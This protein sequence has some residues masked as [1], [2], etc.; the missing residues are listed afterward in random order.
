MRNVL[1]FIK[2]KFISK[3]GVSEKIE[4]HLPQY[5]SALQHLF[6]SNLFNFIQ[7][8]FSA[9]SIYKRGQRLCILYAR[10]QRRDNKGIT[11]IS[12][13]ELVVRALQNAKVF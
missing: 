6:N 9:I 11:I 3:N 12:E 5:P 7:K 1:L 2:F 8:I 10:L 4:G 13:Y